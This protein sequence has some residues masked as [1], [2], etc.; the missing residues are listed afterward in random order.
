[1]LLKQCGNCEYKVIGSKIR[2]K[3][4]GELVVTENEIDL[5]IEENGILY[6]IEIKKTAN[7]NKRM[8]SSF[9]VLD[10]DIEK[11]RGMGAIVCLYDTKLYLKDDLVVL[12]LEFI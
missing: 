1:M 6:P 10:Q 7:P 9:D 2:T 4:D 5:I 3:E 11:K 8:A 12:P